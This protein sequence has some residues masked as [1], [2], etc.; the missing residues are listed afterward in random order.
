MVKSLSYWKRSEGCK[1]WTRFIKLEDD[2]EVR[3]IDEQD[4]LLVGDQEPDHNRVQAGYANTGGAKQMT[5][6]PGND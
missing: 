5:A 4:I 6:L 3:M 2:T 1:S